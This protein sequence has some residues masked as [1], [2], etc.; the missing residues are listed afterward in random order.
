MMEIPIVH[1][2]FC[3]KAGW[4][5]MCSMME[6]P[7]GCIQ[8][9]GAYRHGVHTGMGCIQAWGDGDGGG[10][11]GVGGG[12]VWGVSAY[13]KKIFWPFQQGPHPD[14]LGPIRSFKCFLKDTICFQR[15]D[16]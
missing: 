15:S 8:A 6:I 3:T 5:E 10:D 12:T 1:A 13:S 4:L 7:M 2:C 9:W 16:K 14:K 11:G